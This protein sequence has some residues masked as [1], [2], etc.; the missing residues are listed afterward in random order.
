MEDMSEG[1]SLPRLSK[2]VVNLSLRLLEVLGLDLLVLTF[3]DLLIGELGDRS[4][5]GLN[6]PPDLLY[7]RL[8]IDT[9]RVHP[10]LT[11]VHTG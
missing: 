6:F 9:F 8:R 11:N 2:E 3:L 10:Q 1:Y 7:E 5:A 4:D